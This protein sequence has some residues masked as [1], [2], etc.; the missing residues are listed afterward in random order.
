MEFFNAADINSSLDV[1]LFDD[2][3]NALNSNSFTVLQTQDVAKA[4]TYPI[5]YRT[6]HTNYPT[7]FVDNLSAFT[8]TVI[9]PCDNPVSMTASGPID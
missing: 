8:V 1:S 5:A 6:Y 2:Q 7:N 4:G 3:Q 9:D